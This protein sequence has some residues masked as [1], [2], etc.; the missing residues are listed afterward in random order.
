MMR[1]LLTLFVRS[2]WSTDKNHVDDAGMLLLV[3]FKTF[4]DFS[5]QGWS[6]SVTLTPT[7]RPEKTRKDLI[8]IL[9]YKDTFVSIGLQTTR[10]IYEI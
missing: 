7:I 5:L 2:V 8:V 4:E 10:N 9:S 3:P 6:A 1:W